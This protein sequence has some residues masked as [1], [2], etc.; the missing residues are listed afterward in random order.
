MLL[1]D[2]RTFFQIGNIVDIRIFIK[3]GKISRSTW[4]KTPELS[5]RKVYCFSRKK[6]TTARLRGRGFLL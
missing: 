4:E 3:H 5:R 1:S 2:N 6:K